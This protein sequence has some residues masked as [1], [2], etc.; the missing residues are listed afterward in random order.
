MKLIFRILIFFMMDKFINSFQN[1]LLHLKLARYRSKGLKINF[2]PQGGFD[3]HIEGDLSLFKIDVTS[4]L[5]SSTYIQCDGGLTIG[6]YFHA[7]RS[8]TIYTVAHNYKDS[9][10]I[11]YDEKIEFKSVEICDF[12]WVGANV[13]ILPGVTLGEGSIVGACSI[14][15]KDVPFCAIV[16]GNPAEIVGYRNIADFQNLKSNGKFY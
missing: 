12:V 3:L 4:H 7:G 1:L 5:K 14:V 15:T 13:T 2:I 6:R 16:A 8:L 10:K 11:P 9:A